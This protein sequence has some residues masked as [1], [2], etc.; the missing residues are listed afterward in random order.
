VEPADSA[1][2]NDRG[3]R[4]PIAYLIRLWF[5]VTES[6]GRWAYAASGLFLALLKY[7][8]EAGVVWFYTGSTFWPWDF[9][10]PA[11]GPRTALL[12]PGP[13]WLAWAW[14]LWTLPFLWIAVSM[15]VRRA[16]D[17]GA[18]PWSGL[19]VLVPLVNLVFMITM[20]FLPSSS[21]ER[22]ARVNRPGSDE[23]RAKS[24]V[25]AVGLSLMIGGVMLFVSVYVF[26]TYGASLFLGTPFLM[27]AAAAYFFNQPIPRSL[28]ASAM[29][30]LASVFFAGVAMMLFALEGA[31]CILFVIPLALP[32]GLLGGVLGKAIADATRQ[33]NAGLA[34][35]IAL[36][37]L[38]AGGE[39]LVARSREFMVL[40]TVEIA[41]PPAD[42][43]R[44]VVSFPDLPRQRPWYFSLGIACPERAQIIGRGVGAT[45]YCEFT[46]GTFVEPITAW[47]Q[48]VRLA[49]DVTEQ[50][51]PMFELTPYPGIEPPHLHHSLR[52]T[53][54][55]FKLVALPEGRTRLE[56]RTWYRFEMFPQSYMTIW[57]DMFIHRIHQ[58]VLEHIKQLAESNG[59]DRSG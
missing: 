23:H 49:F 5:G 27:S 2:A 47:E 7:G 16:A 56:G 28:A 42:V 52:S 50:P 25:M 17:A 30:G 40:T 8:V 13:E 22:W 33:P 36:L 59:V 54:G 51:P 58:R 6:V 46:T 43:W 39:S 45:R 34:A 41:A 32:I 20:C 53:R 21:G 29:V 12:Q 44:H 55:E 14:F 57:S 15:S 19:L 24:A 11:L 37:P 1:P 31:I 48:P 10:N 4:S 38:L 35:A 9:L 3:P 18:S 26:S